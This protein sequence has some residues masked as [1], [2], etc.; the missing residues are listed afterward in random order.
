MGEGR[1]LHHEPGDERGKRHE[2]ESGEKTEPGLDTEEARGDHQLN[3]RI[4]QDVGSIRK[5]SPAGRAFD[6]RQQQAG[7]ECER[8][9]RQGTEDE[10]AGPLQECK[11][12]CGRGHEHRAVTLEPGHVVV[13]QRTHH[14]EAEL[15]GKLNCNRLMAGKT[16]AIDDRQD[17]QGQKY[18]IALQAAAGPDDQRHREVKHNLDLDGP[19]RAVHGVVLRI[20][21]KDAWNAVLQEVGKGKIGEEESAHIET[22]ER[23]GDREAEEG[24]QPVAGKDAPAAIGKILFQRRATLVAGEDEEARDR[25]EPLDGDLSV[26]HAIERRQGLRFAEIV[27]VVQDDSGRE[28]ETNN[29]EV[30][31]THGEEYF[32]S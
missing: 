31:L 6:M 21:F 3:D 18:G 22:M 4:V 29:V 17:E 15:A 27:T 19:E 5:I 13:D 32:R 11:G 20:V 16:D 12:K 1:L 2:Q 10:P 7:S 9:D 23:E 25:E 26:D 24:R 30:I 8:R 28:D 14:E